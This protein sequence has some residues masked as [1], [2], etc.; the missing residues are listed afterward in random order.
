MRVIS[1]V[2]AVLP[3]LVTRFA[4]ALPDVMVVDGHPINAANDMV[5]VGF[6]GESGE[7]AVESTRTREQVT[8]DP[9]H[10]AYSVT[11]W[12]Y[13][14]RGDADTALVRGLVYEYVSAVAA[15]L[16]DDPTLGGLVGRMELTTESLTTEQVPEGAQA[17]LRF[18]ISVDAWTR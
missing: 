18:V 9:H 7:P 16:D 8:L 12:A 15:V 4:A 6:S 14:L 5:C 2:P 10:E 11:C 3:E 13:A 1:T 17:A